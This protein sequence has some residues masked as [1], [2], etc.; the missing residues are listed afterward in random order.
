MNSISRRGSDTRQSH[1]RKGLIAIGEGLLILVLLV[2]MTYLMARL[3]HVETSASN[4]A[5]LRRSCGV[6]HISID[7]TEH[8]LWLHRPP[9]GVTRWNMVT[10]RDEMSLQP[11]N[12][13]IAHV[14]HSADGA[15]TM[16][17]GFN[18]TAVLHR[19][20]EE[21]K[22]A[23]FDCSDGTVLNVHVSSDGTIAFCIT[24]CG[25]VYGWNRS[26]D[27][28]LEFTYD[29]SSHLTIIQTG[30]NTDGRRL[31]VME[32]D[33]AVSFYVTETGARDQT[34]LHVDT[35]TRALVWS[36]DE[37]CIVTTCVDGYVRVYDVATDCIVNQGILK[38]GCANTYAG[39]VVKISPDGRLVAI[40]TG[41]CSIVIWDLKSGS[42][43]GELFG[44]RG[45]VSTVQF[46]PDS[47]RL[48]S[49]SYDDTV[50]EW[51]LDTFSQLRIVHGCN[52][53]GD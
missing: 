11:L 26:G 38:A 21:Q 39:P 6:Y 1:F 9:G 48:Y 30:M 10:D 15:T 8:H 20:G 29:L 27:E 43:I 16:L 40:P 22:V 42:S 2:G 23:Y 47:A 46:S 49:G 51:S 52:P 50:R 28:F 25:R 12:S 35:N 13:E 44:H 41:Q 36:P 45:I 53:R 5:A 32:S 17:C 37:T 3:V 4:A 14:A 31:F 18:E 19:E 7:S 24:D 34:E 33:G